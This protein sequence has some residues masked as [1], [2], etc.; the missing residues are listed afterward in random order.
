MEISLD[1]LSEFLVFKEIKS[2]GCS[3]LQS[4]PTQFNMHTHVQRRILLISLHDLAQ[5]F[6]LESAT[7]SVQIQWF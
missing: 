4:K 6:A 2:G 7:Y 5:D 1:S 3:G